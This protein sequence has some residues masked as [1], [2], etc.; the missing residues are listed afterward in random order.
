MTTKY[1]CLFKYNLK[2]ES[3]GPLALRAWTGQYYLKDV[4]RNGISQGAIDS[5]WGFSWESSRFG[6]VERAESKIHQ[7]PSTTAEVK[8]MGFIFKEDWL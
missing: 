5:T 2:D 6:V 7:G 8:V 4:I 1:H 3:E